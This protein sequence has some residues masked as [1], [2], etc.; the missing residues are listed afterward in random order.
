MDPVHALHRL[1]GVASTADLLELTSEKKLRTALKH[2]RLARFVRGTYCLP[3]TTGAVTEARL[4]GA[5]LSHESAA[6]AHGWPVRR[7]PSLTRLTKNIPPTRR[8]GWATTAEQTLL[9]CARDLPFADALCVADSA[10]RTSAVQYEELQEIARR[11]PAHARRVV[12]YADGRAANPF[13]STLRAL[14]IEAG[15]QVATQWQVEAQGTRMRVDVADPFRALA[16]E[17][18]SWAHHA[19]DRVDHDADCVRYNAL[20][21]AGWKVLRFT[22]APV[23]FDPASVRRVLERAAG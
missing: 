23:M 22:W 10:L 5:Y 9:D 2:G 4:A 19:E 17:A 13:E 8:S 15:L 18:D 21:L 20:V 14:A 7:P 12:A 6:L 3:S 16:L 11:W 1:G